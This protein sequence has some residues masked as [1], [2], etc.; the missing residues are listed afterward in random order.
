MQYRPQWLEK[1]GWKAEPY[2]HPYKVSW[3]N[4]TALD[5]K[6]QCLVLI[7]F[8]VYKDEIWCDVVTIDVGQIM[9]GRPW[10]YNND[11]TIHGRSNMCQFEHEGKK[12]KFN[13]L[14][15]YN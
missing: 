2:P 12:I 1:V 6:Q 11:I 9:L 14:P 7:E 3:I 8:D 15:T 5:V 13:T 4:S 10:L